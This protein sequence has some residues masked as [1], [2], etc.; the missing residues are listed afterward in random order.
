MV[1]IQNVTQESSDKS[2]TDFLLPDDILIRNYSKQMLKSS[3]FVGSY[4]EKR[5]IGAIEQYRNVVIIE[6]SE[7]DIINALDK[8]F[9]KIKSQYPGVWTGYTTPDTIGAPAGHAVW[10]QLPEDMIFGTYWFKVKS[11]RFR[12]NE[13][14]L[15]LV[16][17][18]PFDVKNEPI[19]EKN[20][21][22]LS[23]E[24]VKGN[25]VRKFQEMLIQFYGLLTYENIK[26]T[27]IFLS[28]LIATL[29]AAS[30][31]LLKY[32]SEFSLRLLREFSVL[33]KALTPIMQRI[34]EMFEKVIGGF[35]ILLAMIWRDA[36]RPSNHDA[37]NLQQLYYQQN[38]PMIEYKEKSFYQARR[39]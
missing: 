24:E 25:F 28:V 7:S 29:F 3:I 36:R 19:E 33:I 13:I 32:L 35:Y 2:E 22:T 21:Q 10:V 20:I 27:V 16:Q 37:Q 14:L 15:Q 6:R 9:T 4:L 18:R 12:K 5:Y 31:S 8:V 39:R 17:V 1:L 38:R 26:N 23:F 30:V 34:V 11:V